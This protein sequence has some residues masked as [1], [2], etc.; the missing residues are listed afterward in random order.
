MIYDKHGKKVELDSTINVGGLDYSVS[1]IDCDVIMATSLKSGMRSRFNIKDLGMTN[2]SG[3][4]DNRK[5]SIDARKKL[6]DFWED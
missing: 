4:D 2:N 3:G 5:L 1:D 6:R